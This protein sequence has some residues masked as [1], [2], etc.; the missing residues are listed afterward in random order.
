MSKE[1]LIVKILGIGDVVMS[2]SIIEWIQ[3]N[4]PETKLTWVVGKN[5][6]ELLTPFTDFITPIVVNENKLFGK[7]F[8]SRG[9]ELLRIWKILFFKKFDLILTLH[10][11]S[12][13][14]LISL[15]SLASENRF[16]TLFAFPSALKISI[17]RV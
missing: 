14:R 11:D 1:V 16:F 15:F 17:K 8:L 3:R 12:R 4:E 6:A 5:S 7:S 13:F 2:F 9:I 10:S